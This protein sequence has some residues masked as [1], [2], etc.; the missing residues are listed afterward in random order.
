MVQGI[1]KGRAL[2]SNSEA[3][4]V[5]RPFSP[6]AAWRQQ[7]STP[8]HALRC[9]PSLRWSAV[10]SCVWTFSYKDYTC[11]CATCAVAIGRVLFMHAFFQKRASTK[12]ML[13]MHTA[14]LGGPTCRGT[15]RCCR[16]AAASRGWRAAGGR[17]G[18]TWRPWRA[19][20]PPS[21]AG[22]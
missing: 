17:W 14:F 21:A 20:R 19:L 12:C 5:G 10:S 1:R 13:R 22:R 9:A 2:T 7:E 15:G 18:T 4:Q 16:A 8:K 3:R 11:E 6:L